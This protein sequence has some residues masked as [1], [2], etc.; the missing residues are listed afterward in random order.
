[1]AAQPQTM[2]PATVPAEHS[3]LIQSRETGDVIPEE[4]T[5]VKGKVKGL[6]FAQSWVHFVA[7][8]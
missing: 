7:G 6:R 4:A 1:M 8:G 3:T 5:P 2:R